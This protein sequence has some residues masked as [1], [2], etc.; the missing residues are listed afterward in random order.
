MPVYGSDSH[1]SLL[2][3]ISH[4]RVYSQGREYFLRRLKQCLKI[5]LCVGA[6]API[7]RVPMLRAIGCFFWFN[8]HHVL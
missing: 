2:S 8:Y 1:A 4:G 6:R 3:D 5:A 7:R